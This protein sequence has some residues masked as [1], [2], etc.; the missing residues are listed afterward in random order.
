VVPA[1]TALDRP[2]VVVHGP[3]VGAYVCEPVPEDGRD[4]TP[5][6][7][8]RLQAPVGALR[9]GAV[10][11]MWPMNS[12]V[13]VPDGHHAIGDHTLTARACPALNP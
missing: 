7:D 9:A 8:F 2:F 12:A 3:P 10:I 13:I 11:E 4:D 1:G 6:W 5:W